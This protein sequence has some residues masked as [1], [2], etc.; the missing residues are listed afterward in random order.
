MVGVEQLVDPTAQKQVQALIYEHLEK[1][2]SLRAG[3]ILK[4][5]NEA[6]KKFWCVI[7]HPAEA[8]PASKP[9][10]ELAE[11]KAVPAPKGGF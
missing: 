5:W 3:E 7:P 8:K 11:E 4:N 6:V 1:T 9:V 10:H 2:D